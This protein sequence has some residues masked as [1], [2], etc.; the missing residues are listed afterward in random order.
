[1]SS[2]FGG[3]DNSAAN[4]AR[5][6]Q[7]AQ[8][9]QI[10]QG[11]KAITN[12]F[13]GGTY[14]YGAPTTD[15]YDPSKQYYTLSGDKFV[16][17]PKDPMY[18]NWASTTGNKGQYIP[19]DQPAGNFTLPKI[20]VA[21]NITGG[22]GAAFKP[23]SYGTTPYGPSGAGGFA[24]IKTPNTNPNSPPGWTGPPPVVPNPT[25]PPRQGKTEEEY[26][27]YLI[28]SGQ[29]FTGAQTTPG[30]NQDFYNNIT[31]QYL[32][33]AMPQI[34]NQYQTAANQTAYK[35]ADQGQLAGGTARDYLYGQLQK[36]MS[37]A[38]QQAYNQG[39]SLSQSTQQQ[40]AQQENN[41][42]NQL[43]AGA[44]P[45]LVTGQALTAANQFRAPQAL[46]AV[47]NLFGTFANTYLASQLS[48]PA[49]SNPYLLNSSLYRAPSTGGLGSSYSYIQ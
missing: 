19:A 10:A 23:K 22:G 45:A 12:I 17:N 18:N 20:P 35:L 37:D 46:P 11:E 4:A 8:Q 30:F 14:G 49:F 13:G 38:Q 42:I 7:R 41:L 32:N 36:T 24:G 40:V 47:G 15:Y 34:G 31:Q 9:E 43:I 16:F 48:N 5:L 39:L 27:N 26:L 29:L 6:N 28:Q 21:R 3:G 2:I 33:Y 25:Q 1:M 44:S